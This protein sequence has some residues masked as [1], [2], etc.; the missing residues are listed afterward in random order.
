MMLDWNKT[1]AGSDPPNHLEADDAVAAKRMVHETQYLQFN[2]RPLL[3][4]L[5]PHLPHRSGVWDAAFKTIPDRPSFYALHHLWKKAG[6]DGGFTWIHC[7]P[8]EG[9]TNRSENSENIREVFTYFS[10]NRKRGDRV[11]LPGFQ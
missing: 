2:G 7:D 1:P 3:A 6:G 10:T 11:S 8:W 9:H 5:R 4:Q